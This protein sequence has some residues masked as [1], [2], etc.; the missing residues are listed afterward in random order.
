L[1]DVCNNNKEIG[2]KGVSLAETVLAFDP[3][4]R[5]SIK[6]HRCM[7]SVKN[8]LNPRCGASYGN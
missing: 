1:K 5:N 3:R 8:I 4:A 6:D 2:R 7:A